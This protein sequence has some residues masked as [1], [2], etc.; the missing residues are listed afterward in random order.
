M[1]KRLDPAHLLE[2]LERTGNPVIEENAAVFIWKG[3]SAPHLICDLY[4]WEENPR[5]LRR[6]AEGVHVLRL[7]L[8]ADAYLEYAFFDPARGQRLRDPFNPRRTWNGVGHYNH[9]FYMPA[10]GPNPLTRPDPAIPHGRLSRFE[11]PTDD[12]A[13]GRKRLVHLYQPPSEQPAPLLVVYDGSD[14]LRRGR[15]AVIVDNLIAQ[16]RIRPI[17]LALVQNGG[18]ARMLEYA[19]SEATL[20]F[21]L[22]SVLPLAR[23]QMRLIDPARQPGVYGVLGASMGG[24]MAVYT[25]L[26]LPHIFGRVISQAGA[27]ELG[28]DET[29]VMEMIRHMPRPP[30]RLWLDVGRMDFLL[31]ANR[32]MQ[33]LLTEKGY[34]LTYAETGGAHN[35]TTWRDILGRALETL[36]AE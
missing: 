8:P 33:A 10:A 24:L 30:I 17:A 26:R 13:A 16:K 19:C 32:K 7:P 9:Y 11:I 35:Y 4:D 27:F 34:P 14:Y 36:F 20:G 31:E 12:L 18:A 15:L 23:R 29:I 5:P 2:R 6:L 28:D 1:S 21:L 22:Q 3:D 25:A